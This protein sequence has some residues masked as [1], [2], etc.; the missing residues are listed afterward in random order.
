MQPSVMTLLSRILLAIA[1]V[2]LTTTCPVGLSAQISVAVSDTTVQRLVRTG[3][4]M[5]RA[6]RQ[7]EAAEAY[8]NAARAAQREGDIHFAVSLV[9]RAAAVSDPALASRI[10]AR[11]GVSPLLRQER[12]LE[13]E[14][15]FV[16]QTREIVSSLRI[17][18]ANDL[19]DRILSVADAQVMLEDLASGGR[20]TSIRILSS[21]PGLEVRVRRWAFRFKD[22]PWETVRADTTL[23]GRIRARYE[24]CY[25]NPATRAAELIDQ[26]CA[27]SDICSITLPSDHA[28]K[29]DD[30]ISGS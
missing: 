10:I 23:G 3:E 30:C 27:E 28:A 25:L 1:L 15:A 5:E 11:L 2:V 20:H 12:D 21:R 9:G 14:E 6:G 17:N 26:P 24:F 16:Q 29:V 18:V 8:Q 13:E 22:G 4:A 7:R 19:T